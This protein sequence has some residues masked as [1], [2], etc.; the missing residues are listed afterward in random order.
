MLE[1]DNAVPSHAGI[2]MR[3]WLKPLAN[4]MECG[5]FIRFAERAS[6]R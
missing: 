4:R 3:T 2:F 1:G 6:P 5:R